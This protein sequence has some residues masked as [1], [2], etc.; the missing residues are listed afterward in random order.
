MRLTNNE[1]QFLRPNGGMFS[2]S[3]SALTRIIALRQ[4]SPS[5]S[6]AGGLLLGR[7]IINSKDIVVDEVTLPAPE[8]KR[9]RFRFFR[10]KD[11]HQRII[12]ALWKSSRGTCNYLGEWHTHP[13]EIPVPSS[14]DYSSWEDRMTKDFIDAESLFF[15]IVG[16]KDVSVFEGIRNVAEF[17]RLEP[18]G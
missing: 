16:T 6:E 7:Y 9:S 15:I 5:S 17:T 13:E 11:P 8:D 4:S 14:I 1:L 18:R 12:D 10:S 2:V 3:E